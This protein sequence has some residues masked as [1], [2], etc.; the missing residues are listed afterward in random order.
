MRKT[1]TFR[2]EFCREAHDVE[3]DFNVEIVS[4]PCG[5]QGAIGEQ[6]LDKLYS[7]LEVCYPRLA[8]EAIMPEEIDSG[9]FNFQIEIVIKAYDASCLAIWTMLNKGNMKGN[10][11]ALSRLPGCLPESHC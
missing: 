10:I 8:L 7:V 4:C 11:N 9:A 2:C 5:A 3:P 6:T 1:V